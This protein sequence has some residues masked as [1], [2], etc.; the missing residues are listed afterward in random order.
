MEWHTFCDRLQP[1]ISKYWNT[2]HEHCSPILSLV[3]Q[4]LE[5]RHI[6]MTNSNGTNEAKEIHHS[7]SVGRDKFGTN[8][9]EE[10]ILGVYGRVA[11]AYMLG[12]I[13]FILFI[14]F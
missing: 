4:S 14:L 9:Q 6:E 10:S 7:G 1:F 5:D 13:F 2:P 8:N 12:M 3:E 11:H